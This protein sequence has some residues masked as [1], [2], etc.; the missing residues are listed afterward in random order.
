MLEGKQA[1]AIPEAIQYQKEKYG[2]VA[3][4]RDA[5]YALAHSGRVPVIRNGTRK[6][7]FPASTIDRLMQGSTEEV[8]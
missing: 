4:G 2:C 1:L 8:A 5:L 7:L 6:L 3:F